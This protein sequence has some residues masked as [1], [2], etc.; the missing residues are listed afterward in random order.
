MEGCVRIAQ[1]IRQRV[2][3]HV[4]DPTRVLN[5]SFSELAIPKLISGLGTSVKK[6]PN[7][8]MNQITKKTTSKIVSIQ[9]VKT[10]T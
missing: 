4:I 6:C 5:D 8:E 2:F 7:Y 3:R 10:F 1:L 9:S